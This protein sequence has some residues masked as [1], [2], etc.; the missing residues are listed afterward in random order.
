MSLLAENQGKSYTY[1]IL[2]QPGSNFDITY[3]TG[4]SLETSN[5]I[6]TLTNTVRPSYMLPSTG[7]I[8]WEGYTVTGLITSV[9]AVLGLMKK[10]K[11]GER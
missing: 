10:R 11:K 8:G 5:G 1:F 7:G 9:G 2:E 6:L 3:G 4:A